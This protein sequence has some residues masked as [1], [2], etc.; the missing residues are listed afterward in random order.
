MRIR[1]RRFVECGGMV[2]SGSHRM[3]RMEILFHINTDGSVNDFVRFS[4]IFRLNHTDINVFRFML[5]CKSKMHRQ[6]SI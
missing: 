5:N 2:L 1:F 6:S 4:N 3:K